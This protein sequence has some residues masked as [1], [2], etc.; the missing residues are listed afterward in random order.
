MNRQLRKNLIR[1]TL[2]NIPRFLSIFAISALG[3]A[4]FSG[5]RASSPDMQEAGDRM[6]DACALSDISVMCSEG[7][8]IDN[9]RDIRAMEGVG[10]V[11]PGLAADAMMTTGAGEELNVHLISLPIEEPVEKGPKLEL[12]ATYDIDQE[13]D[14]IMN[15]QELT[16]GRLPINDKEVA[17]DDQLMTDAGI[18]LGDYVSFETG[19]GTERLRVVGAVFSAKYVAKFERGNS[20]IGSGSSDGFA[21]ASGNAIFKLGRKLPMMGLLATRYTIADVKLVDTVGLSAF[22]D[23]Y[24]ALVDEAMDRIE[25]YGATQDGTWYVYDRLHNPGYSDYF[26]NTDRIAAIGDVFPVIFFIVAVLVSLTTMTRMV[27]EQRVEMGTLKALGFGRGEIMGKY[28]I[29][30]L[31]ACVS[32]SVAGCLIGFKA[33]PGVILNA[34]GIMYRMPDIQLPIRLDTAAM[35]IGA[36]ALC[37]EAATLIAARS[38]LSEAPAALMRP[39]AP[40]AGKRVFL[41]RVRPLWR[42]LNFNQKVTFRNIF[43]YKKRFFM[44]IIGIA[45]SCALLVTGFGLKYSIFGLCDIQFGG[46]WAMDF[47]AYTYDGMARGEMEEMLQNNAAWGSVE[48]AMYCGDEQNNAER[49]GKRV[50]NVHLLTVGESAEIENKINLRTMAGKPIPLSNDGAVVTY[51]FAE[52]MGLSPGDTFDM[53]VDNERY[54]VTVS[55]I[56]ENYIHHYVYMTS[57]YY[58]D[59]FDKEL[60][61]NCI[62]LDVKAQEEAD[63]IIEELLSDPRMYIVKEMSSVYD[64]MNETLAVL[65]YVT[66]VLIVGSAALT[67]VVMM[68]LTNINLGERKRE[69]ATLRVLGFYDKE[70]Y[71]YIFRENNILAVIGSLC[72][73]VLGRYLH[74]Y[75]IKTCEVDLVMFVRHANAQSYIVSFALAIVFALMVNFI[76]RPKVRA[77]DMVES[78][79]SAE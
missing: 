30:S 49:D 17:L 32:G 38:S 61:Y 63:A 60:E 79:K 72:G 22:S 2:G 74:S 13:P 47:E 3:V 1:E 7:L 5:I 76:M 68:N 55:A 46:I 65:D 9:I 70:M 42:S 26:D 41:E 48:S 8:T 18:R 37:I 53:V 78:L 77:V 64:S 14:H 56:T 12:I 25:A 45:G 27:D 66:L 21:Y 58:R 28:V 11:M 44:S 71:D 54:A 34:Y 33:L 31:I 10:G 67:L 59:V 51:K 57:D 36:M 29:Y 6:M 69:L 52:I 20:S 24:R 75:V 23:E 35:A 73:L 19:T 4:F 15:T 43:R 16:A 50:S 39:K 40:P 62:M